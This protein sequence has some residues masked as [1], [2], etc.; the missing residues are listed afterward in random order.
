MIQTNKKEISEH[1]WLIFGIC[2]GCDFHS[3]T[4][5]GGICHVYEIGCNYNNLIM[6][7]NI[8][9]EIKE[10]AK[11]Y[12]ECFEKDKKIRTTKF[13]YTDYS[14]NPLSEKV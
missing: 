12:K 1:D 9:N 13:V 10:L 8:K 11:K 7:I 2:A 6:M 14:G 3:K 5:D 4:F